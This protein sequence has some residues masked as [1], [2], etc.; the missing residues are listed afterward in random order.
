MGDFIYHHGVPF[1]QL[2]T[3]ILYIVDS[4]GGINN[5]VY[6]FCEIIYYKYKIG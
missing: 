5:G 6:Y 1:V 4:S 3:T 2:P